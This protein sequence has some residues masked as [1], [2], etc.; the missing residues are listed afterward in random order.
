MYRPSENKI[1]R[2]LY[3]CLRQRK[4]KFILFSSGYAF[5]LCGG[6]DESTCVIYFRHLTDITLIFFPLGIMIIE[7]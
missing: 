4:K 3:K 2:K 6:L 7:Q 1:I 5:C